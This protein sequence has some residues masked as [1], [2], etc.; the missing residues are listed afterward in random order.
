[1]VWC[2]LALQGKQFPAITPPKHMQTL[3][4]L[5]TID[6]STFHIDLLHNQGPPPSQSGT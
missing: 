3:L 2:K 1:M 4:C 6:A 5:S